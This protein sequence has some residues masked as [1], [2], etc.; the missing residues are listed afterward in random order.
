MTRLLLL[1]L[2]PLVSWAAPRPPLP[3]SATASTPFDLQVSGVQGAPTAWVRWQ[4]LRQLPTQTI[5]VADEF[6]PGPQKVTIVL[7]ADL[8][9]ALPL[10]PDGNTLLASCTDGYAAVFSQDFI[11]RFHPF[12]VLEIDGRG[13]ESWPP[14][15]LTYNPG[16][17]VVSVSPTLA[18]DLPT[19]PDMSHKRPWGVNHLQWVVADQALSS[20]SQGPWADL[21][22]RAIAGRTLWIESCFS[23]HTG[24]GDQI[25]GT[26]SARP[27]EVLRALALYNEPYVRT[28][29][30]SPKALNAQAKMTPHPHYT[31]PELD[32]LLAFLRAEP[33]SP[34][35]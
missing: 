21:S 6:V 18:P 4:D 8:L 3:L 25:G 34:R 32:A 33:R 7:L 13:P 12:L 17:Y 27:F 28:Y 29:I 1:A 14:P 20:L 10:R 30:R 19:H 5:T 23:C 35:P 15:G 11:Q 26:K 9:A 31:D 16:P 2:L 22:P 24:P